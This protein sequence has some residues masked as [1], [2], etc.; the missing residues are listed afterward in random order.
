M[1]LTSPVIKYVLERE[2]K[3]GA[4]VEDVLASL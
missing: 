3:G 1:K 4:P 2:P